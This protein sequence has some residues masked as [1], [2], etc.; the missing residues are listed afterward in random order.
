MNLTSVESQTILTDISTFNLSEQIRSCILLLSTKW[1][2]KDLEFS[3]DFDEQNIDNTFEMSGNDIPAL[4]DDIEWLMPTAHE[5]SAADDNNISNV[6][7]AEPEASNKTN[8]VPPAQQQ[9]MSLF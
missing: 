1:E 9:Q 7:D 6:Q 3:L 2:K 4:D 8:D 5:D